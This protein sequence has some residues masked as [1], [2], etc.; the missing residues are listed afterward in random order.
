MTMD[1]P[2]LDDRSLDDI[3]AQ[4]ESLTTAY[5]A[6]TQYGPWRASSDGTLDLGGALIRLFGRMVDH[7][8]QPL[9]LVPNKH[10]LAFTQL[11]GAAPIPP[12]AA[13]AAIT[14]QLAPGDGTNE[15]P[16]GAQD[17]RGARGFGTTL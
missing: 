3:V 15:V 4:T 14:F 7:L 5:T 13:R 17:A 9:N 16:A 1:A 11:L 8:V 12:R 2:K 6:Q 10:Q